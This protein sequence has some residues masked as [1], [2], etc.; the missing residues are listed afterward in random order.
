MGARPLSEVEKRILKE[1]AINAIEGVLFGVQEISPDLT[2]RLKEKGGAFV[3]LKKRGSLRGCIGYIR[4][5]M[6]LYK[7]VREAAIQ[8]AFHDPRFEPVAREEWKEIEVEISVLSPM[9]RVDSIEEI[10][11]G[12]HGLYIERGPYSG[13]LLPQVA[14]EYAFDRETFLEETCLKA[15]L[16]RDAWRSRDTSIYIFTAEVF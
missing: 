16:G 3:T 5:I 15:G 11:V 9:K 14:I 1:I 7:T 13:L 8:S 10:E 2:E 12:K 4:E 6:P